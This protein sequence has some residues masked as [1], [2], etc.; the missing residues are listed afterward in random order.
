GKKVFI[1]GVSCRQG[2]GYAI[3]RQSAAWG[4][5]IIVH[6]YQPHDKEQEWGA[7]DLN[8]VLN[9]IEKEL[10]DDAFLYDVSGD[11]REQ[12]TPN[13][14]MEGLVK[15]WG[16]VD[17]LVCNQA[18]IGSDG[19]IGDLQEEMLVKHWAINTRSTILLAQPL[20]K[21]RENKLNRGNITF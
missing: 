5:S 14:I 7:D 17:E 2:I 18:L 11:F 21:H 20:A 19:A 13:K 15:K 8:K 4:A 1:T 12:E 9:G 10:I 6:H 16:V 3:A